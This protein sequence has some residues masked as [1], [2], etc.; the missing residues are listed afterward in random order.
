MAWHFEK[1]TILINLFLLECIIDIKSDL[2][3]T[4]TAIRE[5]VFLKY[6]GS[7]YQ[8]MIPDDGILRFE[9]G[10]TALI[11][12]IADTKANVLTFSEY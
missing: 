5:P 1:Y 12:C 2:N 9:N 4:S 3:R 11:A 8:L 7:Q 10:E 6:T